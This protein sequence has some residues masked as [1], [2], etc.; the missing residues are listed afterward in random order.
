MFQRFEMAM[1]MACVLVLGGIRAADV[2]ADED[3]PSHWL[4]ISGTPAEN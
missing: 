1:A 3:A 4:G 2:R